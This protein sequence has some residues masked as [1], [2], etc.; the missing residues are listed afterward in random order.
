MDAVQIIINILL[1]VISTALGWALKVVW[2]SL[3]ALHKADR[4][5]ANKVAA[6][7]VLVAG[8]YVTRDEFRSVV[9]ALHHKLDRVLEALNKKM[10]RR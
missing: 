8:E 6:I 7:E 10:D 9:E 4:D 1:G 3:T 2:D 5:L